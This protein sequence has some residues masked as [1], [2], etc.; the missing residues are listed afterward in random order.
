MK[1][2]RP[3]IG[4]LAATSLPLKIS[5]ILDTSERRSSRTCVRSFVWSW[6]AA[7]TSASRVLPVR[8]PMPFTL[9]WMPRAPAAIA[10]RQF[11]VARP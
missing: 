2:S 5:T 8:S 11:A 10:A 4:V 6:I 7:T 9:V 3:T 1:T